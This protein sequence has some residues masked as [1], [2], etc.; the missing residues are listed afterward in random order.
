MRSKVFDSVLFCENRDLWHD[1]DGLQPQREAPSHFPPLNQIISYSQKRCAPRKPLSKRTELSK[2]EENR[3]RAVCC[4]STKLIYLLFLLRSLSA[5]GSASSKE[6][7]EWQ[8]WTW[9]SW[10]CYKEKQST[11]TDPSSEY[12]RQ[13]SKF[14]AFWQ[15]HLWTQL[16][17]VCLPLQERCLW[18]L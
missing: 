11:W 16:E 13:S 8:W 3:R 7:K 17:R 14:P 10:Q 9:F 1:R 15:K 5:F 12:R 18:S 6:C 4:K 2:R